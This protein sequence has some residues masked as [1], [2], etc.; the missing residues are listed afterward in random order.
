[1]KRGALYL[2]FE[3][4]RITHPNV[5]LVC[6]ATYDYQSKEKKTF[7]LHNN[8]SEQK[9]LIE[10]LNKY[11][12][13]IGYSFVAEARSLIS[14]GLDPLNFEI[15]DLFFEYRC[16]TNN[17]DRLMYGK[18]LVDGKVKMTRRPPPKWQRTEEDS[19]E[20]FRPTHS[21]AE[22]TYKLLGEIRDTD[23]KNKMR[24]LIISD[25]EKFTKEEAKA[26]LEYCMADVE[27]LPEM[28][29]KMIEH[30][31][32]LLTPRSGSGKTYFNLG[33]LVGEAKIR[34][35][36]AAH[37]AWMENRG[38]PVDVE[39]TQNFSK[40]VPHI[41]F[42]CQ[43][44]INSLFPSIKPF[45]WSKKDQ[46]YTW[47]Q[48]ATRKW[49]ESLEVKIVQGWTKTD[50]GQYSL[51]LEAFQK[52][53]DFKHDYPKDNFGAQMVRFLKLKQNL[54]GFLP[55][56]NPDRKTFWSFVGPD[57]RVRAYL[58]P[59]GA[60]SSRSQPGSVG[61]MFLKP[62]WMRA[63]V[64][65]EKD[66]FMAGIDYGAQ[67]FLV[68]A[69]LAKDKAM[70]EAYLSGD[71]YMY[72]AKR[73]GAVPKDGT[74]ET[75]KRERDMFK[76]TC[77]SEGSLIRVRDRGFIPIEK[78]APGDF[79][80]DGESWQRCLGAKFMGRK[81]TLPGEIRATADHLILSDRGEW[82]ENRIYQESKIHRREICQKNGGRY[83]WPSYSW[84]DVWFMACSIVKAATRKMGLGNF[85]ERWVR[86]KICFIR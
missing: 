22:A 86:G 20:G 82:I 75:H 47:D 63:L 30:Y 74:K 76:A 14:L 64:T 24:D 68:Q 29:L 66:K 36:Y 31:K 43:R 15:I 71:P 69:L 19:A 2:D 18:Q 80:W 1:M 7:W 55:T 53:F 10:Y 84:P 6:C 65:P 3:F 51:S 13:L 59:Y 34:G 9:K 21:L 81:E 83:V 50:S 67:E 45:K 72:L 4:N 27:L 38:Y 5:N 57:K 44:E 8:K 23:H 61:F 25:P 52:F 35:R 79:V 62:A 49:V 54:S 78:V 42:D 40:Q 32:E 39:K 58:N 41:L 70:I 73:V 85:G 48:I 33:E 37:T 56:N 77:L 16:L 28:W 11:Q 60:Q 17:N 26:I 46:R 12:L